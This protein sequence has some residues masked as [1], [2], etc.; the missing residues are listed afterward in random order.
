MAYVDYQFYKETYLGS[1]VP[2]ADFDRLAQRASEYLDWITRGKA[3]DMASDENIM[4]A[5][6]AV[7]EAIQTNEPRTFRLQTET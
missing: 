6:C 4:K 2:E 1:A 3:A 7:A 5:A